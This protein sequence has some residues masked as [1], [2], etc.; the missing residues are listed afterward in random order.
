MR[1]IS[2][3]AYFERRAKAE[4]EKAA[5][6]DDP[7]GKRVHLALAAQYSKLVREMNH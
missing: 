5:L 7:I 6:M 1:N 2:D 3:R 4:L